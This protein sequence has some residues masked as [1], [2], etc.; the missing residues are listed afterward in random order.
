MIGGSSGTELEIDDNQFSWSVNDA[1]GLSALS[2]TVTRDSGDGPEIIYSSTDL[3]DATG[4]MDF[5]DYGVGVYEILVVATDGDADWAGDASGSSAGRTAVV[6]E[7]F[8]STSTRAKLNVN[9]DEWVTLHRADITGT[10]SGEVLFDHSE[11]SHPWFSWWSPN[12][13]AFHM[14]ADGSMI[15][16]TDGR[17]SVGG[18][19]FRDGGLV[20][21]FGDKWLERNPDNPEGLHQTARMIASEEQLFGARS[22][23][24]GI[25]AISMAPDG[26]LVISI[27][28]PRSLADGRSYHPGDLIRIRLRQDGSL[29]D[30]SLYFDHNVLNATGRQIFGHRWTDRSVNVDGAHVLSDGRILLTVSRTVTVGDDD[31]SFKDGDVF[32][33]DPDDDTAS[34]LWDED[35]F[36]RNEDVDALFLGIGNGELNLLDQL[37]VDL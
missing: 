34:M 17:G 2:V 16:S 32:V 18:Q 28:N 4:A 15:L 26:D 7:L 31:V 37:D 13:D 6:G 24:T 14:L 25:D 30:S 36:R 35:S 27:D 21:F 9:G 33:Y 1:S 3:A 19:D 22:F 12:L 23:W 29:A 8:L 10:S 20:Q 5:N 11:L